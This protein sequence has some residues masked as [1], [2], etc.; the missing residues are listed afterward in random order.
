MLSPTCCQSHNPL[1]GREAQLEEELINAQL[2]ALLCA[3]GQAG[4]CQ[5]HSF[6][7]FCF[8]VGG[9]SLWVSHSNRNPHYQELRLRVRK[10]PTQISLILIH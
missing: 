9:I 2:N 10:F 6:I 5:I 1:C 8:F 4:A 3:N 7:V